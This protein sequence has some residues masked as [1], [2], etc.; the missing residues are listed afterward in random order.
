VRQ[1]ERAKPGMVLSYSYLW[2]E[3]YKK[4]IK[5]G[6]KN[7]P[8]AVIAINAQAGPTDLVYVV[9]ITHGVPDHNGQKLKLPRDIKQRLGLDDET[10]WVD[11]TEINAFAW[12][13]FDLRPT[14]RNDPNPTCLY[15]S[16][17]SRFLTKVQ[18]AIQQ[19][20]IENKLKLV[21]R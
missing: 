7:R 8:V 10:S 20:R 2:S 19:N 18:Q 14:R 11:A 6:R 3:D 16:L 4:G 17:P 9:P 15:G 21:P 12:P 13:G 5:E 1:P